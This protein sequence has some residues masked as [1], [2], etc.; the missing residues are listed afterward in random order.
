MTQTEKTSLETKVLETWDTL[1]YRAEKW[2]HERIAFDGISN[3][4]PED[5]GGKNYWIAFLQDKKFVDFR[6]YDPQKPVEE[7]YFCDDGA[8]YDHIYTVLHHSN[9]KDRETQTG[10]FGE[11]IKMISAAAL[12]LEIDLLFGSQNWLARPVI[13][14]IYL[15]KEKKK[16]SLLCQEITE[17]YEF[18]NGSYTL[19]RNPPR[20]LVKHICSFTERIIDF[21]EDLAPSRSLRGYHP[22]HKVFMPKELFKGELFIKKIKYP[23]SKPTYLTYQINGR[24]ADRLL[25]PDRDN[26]LESTLEEVLKRIMINFNNL[27]LIKLLIAP[28]AP[29]CIEKNIYFDS[30]DKLTH[31]RLWQEAF[32]ELY[33]AKAILRDRNNP[34]TN[35]D[36]RVQGYSVVNDLSYGLHTLLVSAG[37][38]TAAE[39][40][41][42]SPSY[43]IVL[44]EDLSAEQR[45]IYE[46]RHKADDIIFGR[47]L[48]AEV[49]I[50]SRA[51]DEHGNVTWFDGMSYLKQEPPTIYISLKHIQDPETFL[52]TYAHEATHVFTKSPD[53]CKAFEAGLTEALGKAL[54]AAIKKPK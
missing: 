16:V 22:K 8:G 23:I 53:A 10:K 25:T 43:E 48:S 41:N 13:K 31:P 29:D 42:Y 52:S 5:C 9:K 6:D 3:H 45:D 28:F 18:R 27:E 7:V 36:A 32:H 44:P 14:E 40:L 12:R 20:E 38:K 17:G 19:I 15:P 35:E 39:V 24:E 26:I 34:H 37:I 50:F 49:K 33:G 46:L 47:S 30:L 4:F 11:G 51:Y 2:G 21:R 54:N 1:D